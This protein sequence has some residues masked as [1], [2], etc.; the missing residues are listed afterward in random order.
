MKTAAVIA[1]AGLSSRMKRFKP[2]LPLGDSTIIEQTIRTFRRAGAASIM[3]VTGYQ[4]ELLANHLMAHVPGITTVKNERY[5]HTDMLCS[6]QTGLRALPP[7]YERVFLSPGDVPLVR[8]GTLLSLLRSNADFVRPVY[9]QHT[10]HPIL[11]S[12]AAVSAVLSWH[13]EGGVGGLIRTTALTTEDVCT[14]DPG[15]LLDAD[16]PQ[17]FQKLR[18]YLAASG[19]IRFN[20]N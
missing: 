6:V 9:D 15:I 20:Y 14:D 11:L 3:V 19:P 18:Q 17:D 12:P 8:P 10:G 16:T 13:G 7:G 1:A 2:L 4:S 5:A